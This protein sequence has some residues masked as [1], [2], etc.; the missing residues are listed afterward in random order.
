MLWNPAIFHP[1]RSFSLCVD[2]D[3]LGRTLLGSRNLVREA[4]TVLV[5]LSGKLTSKLVELVDNIGKSLPA[6]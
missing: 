5:D 1:A 4:T 3:G 2:P 6:L